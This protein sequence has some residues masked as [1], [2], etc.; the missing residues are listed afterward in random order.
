M[1]KHSLVLAAMVVMPVVA[2]AAC[3]VDFEGQLKSHGVDDIFSEFMTETGKEVVIYKLK[4]RKAFLAT[5]G[6][7]TC[8]TLLKIMDNDE[9]STRYGIEDESECE[10][11]AGMAEAREGAGE[12]GL[13]A[14]G[15]ETASSGSDASFERSTLPKTAFRGVSLGMTKAQAMSVA[16][17]SF[18]TRYTKGTTPDS[19]GF[20]IHSTISFI[21]GAGESCGSARL[22]QGQEVVDKLKLNECFF[23]SENA[24]LDGFVRQF[25][26]SYKLQ[27]LKSD[28][29]PLENG[30]EEIVH[31]TSAHGEAVKISKKTVQMKGLGR[32]TLPI[33]IEVEAPFREASFD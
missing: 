19:E 2:S 7:A 25:A 8:V 23:R 1:W 28:L 17:D 33:E 3:V 30:I 15:E 14:D 20:F 5:E 26:T 9:L 13:L 22:T 6:N 29:H 4:D 21:D 10:E 16:I 12:E 11:C 32:A 31:G 24:P 18:S 27:A